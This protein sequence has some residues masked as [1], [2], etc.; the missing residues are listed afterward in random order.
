MEEEGNDRGLAFVLIRGYIMRD[1]RV[2][3]HPGCTQGDIYAN[4]GIK[5]KGE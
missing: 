2:T 5:V 4:N 3:N 1:T